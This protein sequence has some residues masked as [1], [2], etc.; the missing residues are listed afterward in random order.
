[1]NTDKDF[2]IKIAEG[3][4]NIS[5]VMESLQE[6]INKI[7]EDKAEKSSSSKTALKDLR[8]KLN[9]TADMLVAIRQDLDETLERC[10]LTGKDINNIEVA[11]R[12]LNSIRI[13]LDEN[14]ITLADCKKWSDD[15]ETIKTALEKRYKIKKVDSEKQASVSSLTEQLKQKDLQIEQL[16]TKLQEL[17]KQLE[18]P[19]NG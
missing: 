18:P 3:Y 7:E 16:T 9:F 1:M 4:G 12:K 8:I 11:V 10:V 14:D 19:N 13:K 2:E 15:I 6:I 17:Q 5:A